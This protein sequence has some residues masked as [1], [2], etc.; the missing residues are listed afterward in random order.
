[1]CFPPVRPKVSA[2]TDTQSP[3]AYPVSPLPE[4]RSQTAGT[5]Q[6]V[7]LTTPS[8]TN[9]GNEANP[10]RFGP[11]PTVERDLDAPKPQGLRAAQLWMRKQGNKPGGFANT[12]FGMSTAL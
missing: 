4:G 11:Q 10:A 12:G 9:A 3:H 6:S 5:S 8:Q 2:G 7:E 1:M